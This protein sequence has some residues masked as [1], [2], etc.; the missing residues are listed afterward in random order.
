[1]NPVLLII[2]V[3]VP[4]ILLLAVL[5][6]RHG[7]QVSS[8][9]E[10]ER[11]WQKVDMEAFLNLVDPA[12]ERYLRR[13]LPASEFRS[14]QRLRVRAMWEY[15]GRLAFNSRLMM[16]AGQMVQHQS[17]GARLQEATHLVAAASRM[18]MLIFAAD[19]Y[20]A[21]RFILPEMHD[22]IRNLVGKY[23]GLT[24]AFAH[25]CADNVVS[26]SAAS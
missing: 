21:V 25:T 15:T 18:R 14:L 8:L 20:L 26:I 19:V 6:T 13:N 2:A 24:Q 3:A 4:A 7:S 17:S 23:Q 10:V 9:E 16:S 12:E 5:I 1:M 11:Q 22:P